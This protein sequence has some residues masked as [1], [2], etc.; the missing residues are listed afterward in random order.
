M[1]S[2]RRPV[3]ALS[4]IALAVTVGAVRGSVRAYAQLRANPGPLDVVEVRPNIYMIAGAGANITA[5][6]G[7]AGVIL[8]DSGSGGMAGHVVEVVNRISNRPI[9]YIINTSSDA[10]HTGGNEKLS[11][12]GQTILGNP[13]SSGVSED[14]F[15][16]GGAASVLAHER[17]FAR[18]S[19]EE[20]AFPFPQRPTKTYSV[21]VYS[22]YLNGD[23]I[24]VIHMPAAHSDGDSAV[25]F[26]RADVIVAGDILDMTRFPVIDVEHGG[27]VQGEIDALN[28]LLELAIPAIPQPWRDE[29]TL[30]VPGHGYVSDSSELTEYRNMVTIMRDR[31]KEL[32]DKGMTLA[33]VTAADPTQGYRARYASESDHWT[34]DKFVEAV[35]ASL[36]AKR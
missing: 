15:T 19:R 8:V 32:V 14:V 3:G 20:A 36:T 22:M 10:D 11:R 5:Q 24:Q 16:N 21:R 26:R 35:Y 13:G 17:V 7:P 4:L 28:R 6:V 12:S 30:I 23:G 34:T 9:R 27:T 25:F 29:R 33:Q 2:C 1:K 18:M 31:V